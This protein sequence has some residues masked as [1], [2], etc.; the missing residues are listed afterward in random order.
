MSTLLLVMPTSTALLLGAGAS[1]DAR[2]PLTNELAERIVTQSNAL[3]RT[4]QPWVQALNF[5][6]GSMV[7][8]VADSGGNPLTAVNIERLISAV[9][10]LQNRVDH[11]ASPFVS[12]WKQGALGFGPDSGQPFSTRQLKESVSDVVMGKAFADRRL[13]DTIANIARDA[14]SGSPAVFHEV[15]TELLRGIKRN[16]GAPETVAYLEPIAALAAEQGGAD[17]ITLNYDT[18]IEQ[19]CGEAGTQVDTGI[20]RYHPGVPL[21]FERRSGVV[22]LYKLHGSLTWS[23]DEG[24][25]VVRVSRTSS[26]TS[27]RALQLKTVSATSEE[28]P[29]IVVGDR[30]K[31]STDGP[32]LAM[33]RA[34]EDALNRNTN[35]VIVG[36]SFGDNHIN[37]LIRNWMLADA[38]RTLVIVEPHWALA[39]S[40]EDRGIRYDFLLEYGGSSGRSPLHDT[41]RRVTPVQGRTAEVL[42][43]ALGV[44]QEKDPD[45]W[46]I[47]RVDESETGAVI[48]HNHGPS[49]QQVRVSATRP[50]TMRGESLFTSRRDRAQAGPTPPYWS[51]GASLPT[52]DEGASVTVYGPDDLGTGI[53]ELH[54]GGATISGRK[55]LTVPI[56]AA[57]HPEP[58]A[59]GPS[60][61]VGNDP[62]Q[63][64]EGMPGS[65]N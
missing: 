26:P 49:L 50:E 17:V 48:V 43:E 40:G 16:L 28:L 25:G 61:P 15:E 60:N 22:N 31:L 51:R 54:V 18:T 46:V 57:V 39:G 27:T 21:T 10:L 23:T 30:E 9:R 37:Q 1:A 7:G 52:L 3:E 63:E 59:P 4:G 24:P 2:L 41:P 14:T 34:A 36:Y 13:H 38:Q 8:Y 65:G 58:G 42:A 11:E 32:T 5:V 29:W 44:V 62:R 6:Y 12:A 55:D 56:E 47:A 19:A 53:T 33:M 20:E 35:L 45:P 64:S